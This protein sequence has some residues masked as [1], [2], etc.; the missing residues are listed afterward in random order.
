MTHL[1]DSANDF[2]EK[3]KIITETCTVLLSIYSI[4][5]KKTLGKYG[6]ET[7]GAGYSSALKLGPLANIC[8][9]SKL[10]V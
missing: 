4:Y 10:G 9:R 3:D 6:S 8:D 7:N 1:T 2:S 5:F